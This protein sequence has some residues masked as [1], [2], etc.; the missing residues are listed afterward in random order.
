MQD[1]GKDDNVPDSWE[2]EE[3]APKRPVRDNWE[4]DDEEVKDSWD[5]EGKFQL[6]C[7]DQSNHHRFAHRE[8]A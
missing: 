8:Q 5:Q 4:D 1:E 6:T 7:L 2:D 3:E